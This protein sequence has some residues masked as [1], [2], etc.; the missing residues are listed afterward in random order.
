MSDDQQKEPFAPE[1]RA[2][3]QRTPPQIPDHELIRRIGGGSYGEVWLARSIMGTYRAVKVVYRESFDHDRPFEREFNGIQRFEPISRSHES[4]VDILHVGRNEGYFYY[5][6]E[7][8]DDASPAGGSS[9]PA[10]G[11]ASPSAV[12]QDPAGGILDPSAYVPK[13]LRSELFRQG[14]LSFEEC[15]RIIL[16]LTTALEHLHK[17]GLVH[18]DIKPSNIIFV[19]GL[20]KLADI[21]LVTSVDATRSYVGTEGFLPPEG[22]GTAQ[23][24]IYSLGK[25]LYEMMSGR[26]RQDFPELPTNLAEMPD[27]AGMLEL[28]A[29]VGKACK[30]D[31]RQRYQSAAEMHADLVLLQSGKSVRRLQ[32]L[33]R[34][35]ARVTRVGVMAALVA[36]LAVAA[37]AIAQ[38]Q[39]RRARATSARESKL[40]Q[41]AEA[42]KVKAQTEAAKSQQVAQ[43]LKDM[44]EGV[45]PA[46][47]LGRDTTMLKEILD[48]TAE[49]I[50][51]DLTNQPEVEAELQ[52][53]IGGVYLELGEY[54]KSEKMHREALALRRK[55]FGNEHRDVAFSLDRLA[56]VLMETG[57]LPE[58]EAMFRKVVELDRRLFGN[59]HPKVAT[60]LNNLA[61]VLFYEHKLAEAESLQRENLEIT[62]KTLGP[63]HSE[64]AAALH[65]LADVLLEQGKQAEAE[66]LQR[67]AVAVLRKR[68]GNQHPDLATTLNGLGLVLWKEG[69]LAEAEEVNRE[70][71]AMR[72]KLLG[73]DHVYVATSLNNLALVLQEEVKLDE[74]ETVFRDA[75][76]LYRRCLTNEHPTVAQALNN[77]GCLLRDQGK[78]AEA[79]AVV[80]EGLSLYLKLDTKEHPDVAWSL[81]KLGSVLHVAG[82]LNEAEA[83]YREAL[84]TQQKLLGAEN[85][86]AIDSLGG[87]AGVL[88]D[89]GKLE[90][91]ESMAR[92]ELALRKKQLGNEHPKVATALANLARVLQRQGKLNEAEAMARECLGVHE[93]QL[94]NHWRTWST[95]SLLG[96]ILLGEKNYAAAEPLLVSGYEGM[97]QLGNRVTAAG[98]LGQKETLQR[99]VQ[100]Y[101]TTGRTDKAAEWKQ[102]LAEFDKAA[103]QNQAKA[104]IQGGAATN[105]AI[106]SSTSSASPPASPGKP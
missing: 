47:A 97:R 89:Q 52:V 6:M 37:Y 80:R 55:V 75:L 54:Q 30:N 106:K 49:R 44:L 46:V 9:T 94:A 66:A 105:G 53:V 28:N 83:L 76:A 91:A 78:L 33:E 88:R 98:K 50:S 26:D 85:P 22:P 101:E 14:K 21:G 72:R 86:E 73:G 87:L 12:N 51:A 93:K 96:D 67:E 82:K 57:R 62:R 3:G 43:F 100:L 70:V 27:R 64:M 2:S 20:P 104:L 69:K 102:K 65:N 42:E 63:E 59:E 95:R 19:H 17:H 23:A 34:R 90:E 71:L 25:V 58:S 56:T 38:N 68:L 7:L 35:L 84:A 15:L 10:A 18:R 103:T 5:V 48:K 74:A 29:I 61:I 4:Q 81:S 60:A 39:A 32:G 92:E 16:A 41:E 40:R 77:L 1:A 99:L 13:T 79:E 36:V 45:G 11:L 24:D 8:A 31:P